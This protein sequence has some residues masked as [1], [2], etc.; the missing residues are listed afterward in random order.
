MPTRLPIASPRWRRQARSAML[1][2]RLYVQCSAR[3]ARRFEI[4]SAKLPEGRV[5]TSSIM[6]SS[7]STATGNEVIDTPLGPLEARVFGPAVRLCCKSLCCLQEPCMPLQRLAALLQRCPRTVP[8]V[9]RLSASQLP[10]IVLVCF[11]MH[12]K[13]S[14]SFCSR[15]LLTSMAYT[16]LLF[17][18][19]PIPRRSVAPLLLCV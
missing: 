19:S 8:L 7:H 17:M 13:P 15:P 11:H 3:Q 16:S 5:P 6:G 14:S 12:A 18:A 9:P 4:L 2:C 1:P 10:S